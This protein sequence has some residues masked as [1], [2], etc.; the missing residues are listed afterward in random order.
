MNLNQ[1]NKEEYMF[2]SS[3]AVGI[4]VAVS[5][6]G[7]ALAAPA[8]SGAKT[9]KKIT[10]VAKGSTNPNIIKAKLTCPKPLGKGSQDGKLVLPNIDGY[11][12]FKGGSFTW[13]SRDGKV[14]G[15]KVNAKSTMTKGKGKFK[16]CSM[17]GTQSG[18]L[19]TGTVTFKLTMTCK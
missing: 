3:K 18:E 10:C 9:T 7:V 5:L 17:K 2:K 8:T 12:K 16:G 6:V 1:V 11:W 4:V 13:A 14:V 15:G 19:S